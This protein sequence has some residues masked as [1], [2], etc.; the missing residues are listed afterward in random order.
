MTE[1]HVTGS[2]RFFDLGTEPVDSLC[3]ISHPYNNIS[4]GPPGLSPDFIQ[5][6][7]NSGDNPAGGDVPPKDTPTRGLMTK[8]G[9]GTGLRAWDGIEIGGYGDIRIEWDQDFLW[10]YAGSGN[11]AH[12]SILHN[13]SAVATVSQGDPGGGA[14]G[15][16]DGVT[17][18]LGGRMIVT[19]LAVV[20]GD[21]IAA[22]LTFTGPNSPP[23]AFFASPA[24]AGY[25]PWLVCTGFLRRLEVT[26]LMRLHGTTAFEL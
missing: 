7:T 18:G 15:W 10:A 25:S 21:V 6:F 22:R 24:G 5:D 8:T 1:T 26:P 19:A 16:N 3:C 12:W 2:G 11:T 20:P 13:G 23:T 9:P 14:H 4:E 17:G